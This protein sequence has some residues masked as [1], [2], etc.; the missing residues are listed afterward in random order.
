MRYILDKRLGKPR[1][2][3]D[4]VTKRGHLPC[5]KSNPGSYCQ[6]NIR[7]MTITVCV[8]YQACSLNGVAADHATYFHPEWRD[9]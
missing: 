6:L 4:V 3:L 1:A 8:I 9:A 5:R 7:I 2:S